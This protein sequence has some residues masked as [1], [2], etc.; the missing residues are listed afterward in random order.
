MTSKR[1]ATLTVWIDAANALIDRPYLPSSFEIEMQVIQIAGQLGDLNLAVDDTRKI[2]KAA[3][4]DLVAV[5]DEVFAIVRDGLRGDASFRQFLAPSH[6]AQR[7]YIYEYAREVLRVLTEIVD[8]GLARPVSMHSIIS[9]ISVL[10]GPN[11]TLEIGETLL[12]ESVVPALRGLA[13]DKIRECVMC[14]R[15]LFAKR[16]DQECCS[17]P[18]TSAHRAQLYRLK[19]R[20]YERNRRENRRAKK[21]R[22][23][24]S[25]FDRRRT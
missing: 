3:F 2:V 25:S 19:R 7:I 6:W 14:R 10:R 20:E 22:A 21:A 17:K 8:S 11:G 18:C 13:A 1:D 9:V 16:N 4:P 12:R 23:E 15:L 24:G 5:I